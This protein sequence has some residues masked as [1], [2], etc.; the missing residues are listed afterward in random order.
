MEQTC[1]P[2]TKIHVGLTALAHRR[3]LVCINSVRCCRSFSSTLAFSL[4][5]ADQN[6]KCK[7]GWKDEAQ[8]REPLVNA[9]LI[10][11]SKETKQQTAHLRRCVVCQIDGMLEACK[12]VLDELALS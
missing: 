5:E 7:E 2:G 6:S 8:S 10:T 9:A 1:V 4:L 11:D 12:Q 3:T